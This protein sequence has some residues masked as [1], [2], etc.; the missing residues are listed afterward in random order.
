VATEP[1]A[2]AAATVPT[3]GREEKEVTFGALTQILKSQ[4][5]SIFTV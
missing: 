3:E 5:P 1:A 4:R 2:P